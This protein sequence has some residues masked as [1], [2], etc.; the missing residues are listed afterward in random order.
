MQTDAKTVTLVG[1]DV[2]AGASVRSRVLPS[3]T[4]TECTAS[5]ALP[6][7]YDQNRR[8]QLQVTR[9]QVLTPFPSTA[10]GMVSNSS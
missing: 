7:T 3:A 8:Y 2:H 4:V 10:Y 1:A 9:K 5:P 6:A